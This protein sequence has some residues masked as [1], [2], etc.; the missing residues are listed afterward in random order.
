MRLKSALWLS[1]G[2]TALLTGCRLY[3]ADTGGPDLSAF[4]DDPGLVSLPEGLKGIVPSNAEAIRSI[5]A[6]DRGA[7]LRFVVIGDTV[8]SRNETFK[9]FLGDVGALEP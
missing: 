1:L 7:D 6:R 5:E 8:S 3:R 2:L 4:R 9:A